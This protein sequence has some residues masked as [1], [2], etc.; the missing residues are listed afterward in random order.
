MY[1]STYL[2]NGR[3]KILNKFQKTL[4]HLQHNHNIVIH[5][6]HLLKSNIHVTLALQYEL[7]AW[8]KIIT[9]IIHQ[10]KWSNSFVFPRT[11]PCMT[12]FAQP[13]YKKEKK[14]SKSLVHEMAVK[15]CIQDR[16]ENIPPQKHFKYKFID[17]YTVLKMSSYRHQESK[18][19]LFISIF[20]LHFS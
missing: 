6:F 2:D 1:Q 11:I 19:K 10:I 3:V 17:Y 16:A 14:K 4:T 8:E 7:F 20:F 18:K 9:I 13:V 15:S 12:S 5:L